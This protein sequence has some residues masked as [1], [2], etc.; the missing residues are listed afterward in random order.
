MSIDCIFNF[1]NIKKIYIC[2]LKY[3]VFFVFVLNNI[4]FGLGKLDK[5]YF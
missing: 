1:I 5:I 4:F 3:K 2:E